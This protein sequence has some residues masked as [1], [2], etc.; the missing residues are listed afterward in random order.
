MHGVAG[1]KAWVHECLLYGRPLAFGP[2]L[3][4]AWWI[5]LAF[6]AFYVVLALLFGRGINKCVDT[7]EQRPGYSILTALL[8]VLLA[9]IAIIVLA[10][11]GIGIAVIPFVA[12]ALFF[13]T[14]F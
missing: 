5:A 1:L 9:P 11:T 4:W 14:L 12:A 13:A 3:M 7:L 8:T 6:L 10:I 2:N